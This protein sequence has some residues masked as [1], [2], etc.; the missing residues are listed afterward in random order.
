MKT[1]L[2]E[3]DV[4][5]GSHELPAQTRLQLAQGFISHDTYLPKRMVLGDSLLRVT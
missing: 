5:A 1:K 2:E 3:A 4:S